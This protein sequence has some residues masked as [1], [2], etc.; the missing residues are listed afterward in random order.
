MKSSL[1]DY[2]DAYIIVK[3]T[4][5]ITGAELD[6][7]AKRLHERNKGVMFKNC[8]PFADCI[9]EIDNIQVDSTKDLHVV[10]LMKNLIED[11]DN[12][13]KTLEVYGNIPQIRPVIIW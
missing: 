13:S 7:A 3:G 8:V 1:C 5:T 9:S 6:G 11:S 4:I 10:T 2:S 12:Y